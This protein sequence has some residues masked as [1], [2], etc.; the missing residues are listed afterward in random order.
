MIHHSRPLVGEN[1]VA[2]VTAALRAN[3]VEA[4]G[5]ARRFEGELARMVAQ[6]YG[7]ATCSGTAALHLALLALEVGAGDE[8]LLPSYV[9]TALLNAVNY[10]RAT[11]VFCD[12]DEDAGNLDPRD[13]ERR[14]TSRARAIIVPHL[15]GQP[16][17]LTSLGAFGLPIVEDCAQALGA[18]WQGRPVGGFGIISVFSFYSTKVITTGEGGMACTSSALLAERMRALRD[19]DQREDYQVRFSYKLSDLQASLG[20]AQLARLPE[21]LDRRRRLAERYYA[22]L[23]GLAVAL[24]P[25]R[26]DGESIYYRY[27]VRARHAERLIGL[28]AQRGV[29]CKRPVFRPLHHYLNGTRPDLA[30]TDRFHAQAL[31]LPLYPALTDAQAERVVEA[32]RAVFGSLRP[33]EAITVAAHA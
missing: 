33:H 19:Y 8:V 26:Q 5:Q 23:R 4:G 20:L 14:I 11:A 15:F 27:V 6:R 12:V 2:A 3:P 31:S 7:V 29:E 10:T 16:A 21:M 32:A 13:V 25:R 22:A 17:D 30:R 18:R 1:E 24:P 9:C 28:F